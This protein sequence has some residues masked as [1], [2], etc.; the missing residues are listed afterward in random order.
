MPM[1]GVGWISSFGLDGS[2]K[3]FEIRCLLLPKVM[4]S[5]EKS[6]NPYYREQPSLIVGVLSSSFKPHFKKNGMML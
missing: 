6:P 2:H 3:V 5:S 1:K 4:V